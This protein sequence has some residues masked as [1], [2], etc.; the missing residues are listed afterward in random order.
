[1]VREKKK[2]KMLLKKLKYIEDKVSEFVTDH[3]V[4]VCLILVL[5][6][7]VIC[8][9]GHGKSW[10][11]YC[12]AV[13]G[14]CVAFYQW[15]ADRRIKRSELLNEL[16]RRF[17]DF[18]IEKIVHSEDFG[19]AGVEEDL[20]D[21]LTFM[22]YVCHLYRTNILTK[23]EFASLK[24]DVVKVLEVQSVF[25]IV[26][27]AYCEVSK[28]DDR[29]YHDLLMIGRECCNE[30]FKIAYRD[31]LSGEKDVK[32]PM[33]PRAQEESLKTD[34]KSLVDKVGS[35]KKYKNHLEIL[36]GIFNMGYRGHMKG[37]AKLSE[38]ISVWFPKY[39]S[40]MPAECNENE[41]V[42]VLQDDGVTLN[43]FWPRSHKVGDFHNQGEIRYVF[44]S[45]AERWDGYLFLGVYRF[46]GVVKMSGNEKE[47][48]HFERVKCELTEEDVNYALS[49]R[50][51]PYNFKREVK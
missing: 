34:D 48:Y 14:G 7:A 11:A 47:H 25:K 9:T 40:K 20:F 37:A 26:L 3:I 10:L 21:L 31:L 39:L 36:N 43:E 12:G 35:G 19:V 44:G 18:D 45:K 33:T 1:M 24:W 51:K 46:V 30:Q 17:S 50:G 5:M 4:L 6:V 49:M 2:K 32:I 29:P 23:R 22:S 41:W 27:D 16:I 38:N 28:E 13:I 8:I 15:I 42:N